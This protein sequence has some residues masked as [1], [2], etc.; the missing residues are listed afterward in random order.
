[1]PDDVRSS[2]VSLRLPADLLDKLDK[3]AAA[4]DRPRSWV[5]VHA[6]KEYLKQ[7]GEEI[8]DVQEGIEALD[9][10]D[11]VDFDDAMAEMRAI[12][13]DAEAKRSGR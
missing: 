9:R 1:M 8:L 5:L 6:F 12:I 7:E 3:I 11:S 2:P 4:L 10:G 13:A